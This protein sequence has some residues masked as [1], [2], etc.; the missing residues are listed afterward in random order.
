MGK[1]T[2]LPPQF[3]VA[4]IFG[5]IVG[6]GRITVRLHP[7]KPNGSLDFKSS[8]VGGA[9]LWPREELWPFCTEHKS[10]YAPI[11]QLR[12]QEF[13]ELPCPLGADTFQLLWC[14][15]D[16]HELQSW[17]AVKVFWHNSEQPDLRGFSPSHFKTS[18][19]EYLPKEC[20]LNPERV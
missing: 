8:K 13:P 18:Q 14:P 12:A 1:L 20:E 11:L 6:L 4:K 5:T 16:H 15:N 19:D 10:D 3:D 7:R 2:T 17:P 9:F